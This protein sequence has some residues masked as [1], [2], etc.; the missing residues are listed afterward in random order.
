VILL[1]STGRI[2]PIAAALLLAAC[3][4]PPNPAPPA[5]VRPSAPSAL[6]PLL[7]HSDE[8]GVAPVLDFDLTYFLHYVDLVAE[9]PPLHENPDRKQT[10]RYRIFGL[11]EQGNC[12]SG[13]PRSVVLVTVSDYAR[14]S[15][16]H[17]RAYRLNGLHFWEFI[18]VEE[19]KNNDEGGWFLAFTLASRPTREIRETY[20][21]R[22]GFESATIEKL[23][24][25]EW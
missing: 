16:G 7:F 23:A 9:S 12:A 15:G 3:D 14:G 4:A 18:D 20:R 13:C 19:Y 25:G 2:A 10:R 21:V 5:T 1:P 17:I 24:T 22:V 6:H 8:V 11:H